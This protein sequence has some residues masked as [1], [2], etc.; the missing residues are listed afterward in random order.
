ALAAGTGASVVSGGGP[1]SVKPRRRQT[2]K[3]RMRASVP[4]A[5]TIDESRDA[6]RSASR[7]VHLEARGAQV[8]KTR[9]LL[10]QE[11]HL[12]PLAG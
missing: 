5:P 4:F 6:A 7:D 10:R 3:W 11:A 1:S 2:A 9:L 8:G 12:R